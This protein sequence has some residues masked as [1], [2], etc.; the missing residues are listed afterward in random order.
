[1]TTY[2]YAIDPVK[3]KRLMLDKWGDVE[4]KRLA[5]AA[6]ISE[7][8]LVRMLK[9]HGFSPESLYGLCNALGCTPNDILTVAPKEPTL[10]RVAA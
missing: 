3:V 2:V 4:Q 1:V 5:A 8:T 6:G 7:Q 9:G 10:V